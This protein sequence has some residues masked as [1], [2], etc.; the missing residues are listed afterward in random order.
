MLCYFVEVVCQ[1]S[2]ICVV[3]KLF[4]I[5]F[6]ISK[7][8]KNFED[9]LNCMLLICDG[10]KLLFIDI[11]CVVFECGQVILGEFSQLELELSDI[12]YLYKGVLWFGILLMVGMLMV[13]LI[14]CFCQCY[15]GVELKIVEFGGLMVQQVVSNG[16]FDMVMIVLFVEE[17]SSFIILLLFNYLLCVLMLRIVEWE[18]KILFLLVELVL[19]LLV[20]YNEEFVFSQQ[21]MWLFVEYD[22]KLCIVVCSGQW[23]F[24]VVMVQVGIG[25]VIL[26]ELICQCFDW[27][28][29]CW[30][31]L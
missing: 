8:F 6:I 14:S 18:G 19:Y 25:V 2:F 20:I 31:L 9:E 12:N 3:E 4:V 15:L 30:I 5:Q 26:L 23:D 28:N 22:V 17:D 16:E 27:Q 11:G 29:F 21:L 1:Q 24:F 7:M 13:E 10:C